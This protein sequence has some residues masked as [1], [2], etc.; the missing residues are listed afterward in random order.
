LPTQLEQREKMTKIYEMSD[1]TKWFWD[2][3]IGCWTGWV[4]CEDGVWVM[5]DY[6]F[7]KIYGSELDG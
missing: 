5:E 3:G 4:P 6:Y 2:D 7:M 1:G